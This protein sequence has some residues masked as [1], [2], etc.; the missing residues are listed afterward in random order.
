M[1]AREKAEMW[2]QKPEKCGNPCAGSALAPAAESCAH[3]SDSILAH[4][5][6]GKLSNTWLGLIGHVDCGNG[7]SFLRHAWHMDKT[8]DT[9]YVHVAGN[10][11]IKRG[12]VKGSLPYELGDK[13]GVVLGGLRQKT[14]R[15]YFVVWGDWSTW[16]RGFKPNQTAEDGER[17]D[18]F[19]EDLLRM[20]TPYCTRT[21]H[22]TG[23]TINHLQLM[24]DNMHF[25]LGAR[26]GVR[27]LLQQMGAAVEVDE[28]VNYA[29]SRSGVVTVFKSSQ[30]PP[31]EPDGKE[32]V[33]AT[34]IEQAATNKRGTP[35]TPPVWTPT[36]PPESAQDGDTKLPSP[37][38]HSSETTEYSTIVTNCSSAPTLPPDELDALTPPVWLPLMGV[39]YR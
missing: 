38:S 33:V 3:L 30:L 23:N 39:F 34:D 11:F 6:F 28:E 20:A 2:R 35:L 16:R 15:L 19:C 17:Y 4:P 12:A 32:A 1:T 37:H 13:V 9:I 26:E 21:R 7:R 31:T 8:V 36:K 27:K 22:I 14:T 29:G 24:S 25:A 5:V 18:K 10:D